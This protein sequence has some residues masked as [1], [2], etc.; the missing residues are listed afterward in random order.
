MLASLN[1]FK[2][3]RCCTRRRT[4]YEKAICKSSTHTLTLADDHRQ[5]FQLRDQNLMHRDKFFN[6]IILVQGRK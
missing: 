5:V 1:E 2:K 6:N 3:L 4:V